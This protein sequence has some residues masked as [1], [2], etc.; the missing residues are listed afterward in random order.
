LVAL[1][2]VLVGILILA[3]IMGGSKSKGD[4]AGENKKSKRQSKKKN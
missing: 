2:G 1:G 3:C 4:D